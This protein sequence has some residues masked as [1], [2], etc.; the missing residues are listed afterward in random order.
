M[1]HCELEQSRD[2]NS[3]LVKRFLVN[4][5]IFLVKYTTSMCCSLI[6][7]FF[8]DYVSKY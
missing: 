5:Q 4:E 1:T 8:D 2:V 6:I 3:P 7:K